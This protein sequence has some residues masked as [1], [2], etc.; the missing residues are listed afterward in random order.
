MRPVQWTKN[1]FIFAAL[2]FSRS[3]GSLPTDI[4][5][6]FAFLIFCFLSGGLYIFNDLQDLEEDRTHPQKRR[7]PLASGKLS[8]AL[9]WAAFI[10]LSLASLTAAFLLNRYFFLTAAV[11]LLLQLCYSLK[12]K[13]IVILD[14]FAIA[15]G[16]VLRVVAGGVVIDVP[17]SSWLLICTILLSLF[18]AVGKRRYELRFLEDAGAHRPVLNLYSTELLDQMISVITASLVIAYCLYTISEE[19]IARFGG[20]DLIFSSPFV[21]Y[22]VFRYLY[23]IHQKG[24]G[25]TPEEL[26]VQDKSL[27]AA[28][29]LWIVSVVV[30]IYEF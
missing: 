24:E 17:I 13:H 4:R 3:L 27:L 12:L 29:V 9:A 14:V 26:I 5:A 16:F 20:R 7:R 23:L 22:G 21:L 15:L 10:L 2:L 18:L 30:L 28:I 8:P 19:T 25:G 6:G 1:L 11:Y